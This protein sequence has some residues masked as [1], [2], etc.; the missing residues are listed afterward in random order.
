MLCSTLNPSICRKQNFSQVSA[1]IEI[2]NCIRPSLAV[3][4]S[5]KVYLVFIELYEKHSR[6]GFL[7]STGDF[8][9]LN[10]VQYIVDPAEGMEVSRASIAI[11]QDSIYVAYNLYSE[12]NSSLRIIKRTPQN[13]WIE[14]FS[15]TNEDNNS[16]LL[17]TLRTGL[18]GHLWFAWTN[19]VEGQQNLYCSRFISTNSS[20]S[21]SR[22][23]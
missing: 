8:R 2:P 1:A 7:E 13:S 17:P 12:T 5:N 9:W 6:I 23:N 4:S 15:I 11:Y 21:S 22:F 14:V 3:D 16:Y 18:D 10:A 20:W 19:D